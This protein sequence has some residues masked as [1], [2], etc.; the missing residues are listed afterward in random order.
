M[1][2]SVLLGITSFFM[3]TAVIAAEQVPTRSIAEATKTCEADV[4]NFCATTSCVQ[5]CEKI[6]ENMRKDKDKKIADCKAKCTATDMC[7]LKPIAGA[8]GA[9]TELDK[10]NRDQLIACI[11]QLRDP[12]G[13]I[14]GRRMEDWKKIQTP[15]WQKLMGTK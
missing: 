14:S 15:S 5:Y 10:Q 11:A 3:A 8:S 4:S 9:E 1:H 7:K 6:N 13:K 12:T 2:K